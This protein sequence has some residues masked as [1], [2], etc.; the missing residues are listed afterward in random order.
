MEPGA[1]TEV[2]DASSLAVNAAPFL[3]IPELGE[4]IS[5]VD[6]ALVSSEIDLAAADAQQNAHSPEP[7][8]EQP[9]WM[10]AT[11]VGFG[12]DWSRCALDRLSVDE[13]GGGNSGGDWDGGE[14]GG[15]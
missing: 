9:Q 14:S 1:A 10:D 11:P 12:L 7:V 13:R 4:V 8:S 2:A 15:W 6:L 3:A 5:A